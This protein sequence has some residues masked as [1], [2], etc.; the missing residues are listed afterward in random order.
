MTWS[1]NLD[2]DNVNPKWEHTADGDY[3]PKNV[4]YSPDG[5]LIRNGR[6]TSQQELN[7]ERE[8]QHD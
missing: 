2:G 8:Y 3:R 1:K 5:D 4:E 7:R 6:K